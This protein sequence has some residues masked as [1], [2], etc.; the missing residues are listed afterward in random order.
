MSKE[1]KQLTPQTIE[2]IT[3]FLKDNGAPAVILRRDVGRYSCD[4]LHRDTIRNADSLGTGPDKRVIF[5]AKRQ[6]VG[7]PLESLAQYMAKRGFAIECR[8]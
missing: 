3:Q 6:A 5:G 1:R 4:F 2:Q 7:Y 8:P